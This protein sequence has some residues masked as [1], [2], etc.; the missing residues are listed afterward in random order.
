MS[1]LHL[2]SWISTSHAHQNLHWG[3]RFR[4]FPWSSEIRL[5][6]FYKMPRCVMSH[7]Q[8][9]WNG[10]FSWFW[11]LFLKVVKNTHL[12]KAKKKHLL[13][14]I[15]GQSWQSGFYS[16]FLNGFHV[17][18]EIVKYTWWVLLILFSEDMVFQI[19]MNTIS[20][21]LLFMIIKTLHNLRSKT[22]HCTKCGERWIQFLKFVSNLILF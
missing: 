7:F 14:G 4:F 3:K 11:A 18:P 13:R 20:E 15:L 5:D 19:F 10:G 22:N 8:C 6:G 21:M 12:R 17:S 16:L 2:K 1:L 9:F